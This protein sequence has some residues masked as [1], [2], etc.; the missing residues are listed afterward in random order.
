VDTKETFNPVS[1]SAVDRVAFTVPEFCFRNS[2]SRPTYHRLR[3]EAVVRWRCRW[4]NAIRITAEAEYAWQKRMQEPRKDLD[5]D[6]ESNMSGGQNM[7]SETISYDHVRRAAKHS[8]VIAHK[9]RSRGYLLLDR[10][11]RACVAG[12]WHDL[13][14][15]EALA[16]IDRL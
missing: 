11:N 12:S 7:K 5:N 16:W 6:L 14:A 10:H 1:S 4:L 2:I 13:S 9:S 3:A 15:G 8:G